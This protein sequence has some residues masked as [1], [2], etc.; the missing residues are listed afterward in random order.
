MLLLVLLTLSA[1]GQETATVG[2]SKGVCPPP[3]QSRKE[4]VAVPR[5]AP[6]KAPMTGVHFVGTVTMLVSLSDTGAI[7]EITVV[8]G[9]DFN[10]DKQAVQAIQAHLFQPI[11]QDG[12]AIPGSMMVQRDF[13]RGDSSDIVVAENADSVHDEITSGDRAVSTQDIETVIESGMIDGSTYRNGY[14]G[15]SFTATGATLNGPST[16]ENHGDAARLVDAVST[17]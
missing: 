6:P 1:A 10:L 11:Q 8:K 15:M 17:A 2:N 16:T 3:A 13:W 14:F 4:S 12:K 7:C 5:R 9:I